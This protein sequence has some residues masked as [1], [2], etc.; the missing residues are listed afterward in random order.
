MNEPMT[1]SAI[2]QKVSEI[3]I[4]FG[5]EDA[6]HKLAATLYE[7]LHAIQYGMDHHG[8]LKEIPCGKK[9]DLHNLAA[10]FDDVKGCMEDYGYSRNAALAYLD[11]VQKMFAPQI[12]LLNADKQP[13]KA[14]PSPVFHHPV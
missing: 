10:A 11:S 1:L 3:R 7:S 5:A 8:I 9:S 14:A 12:G 13:V 6:V 4:S 2:K